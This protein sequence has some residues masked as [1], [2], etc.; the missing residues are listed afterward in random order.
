[1]ERFLRGLWVLRAW[2]ALRA[3]GSRIYEADI[4]RYAAAGVPPIAGGASER[5]GVAGMTNE[6]RI[7]YEKMLLSRAVPLMHHVGWGQKKSIPGNTGNSINFRRWERP[8][9][10]TTAIPEGS[11]P[12]ATALTVAAV[13]LTVQ[14]YG[15]WDRFSDVLDA[16]GIDD[17]ITGA[18][19]AFGE[20]MGLTIDTLAR[21]V[22]VAGTNVTFAGGAGSRGAI[23]QAAAYFMSATLLKRAQRE[24]LAASARPNPKLGGNFGAWMHPDTWD[25]LLNDTLIQNALQYA[26]LR[27]DTNP[28]FTGSTFDYAGMRL[29]RSA[30]ARVFGS[31]GLSSATN[32]FPPVYATVV[33][34]EEAYGEVDFSSES[35]SPAKVIV[36]QIGSAGAQDPLDQYGTVGWKSAYG[37]V[38]LN[39]AFLYRIES[40]ANAYSARQAG[41]ATL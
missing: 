35:A 15:A 21:D 24:L 31:A 41:N 37:A 25:D 30:N 2:R 4:R 39:E 23:S 29:M 19:G 32:G 26:G 12:A 5:I 28:L 34:A 7:F 1:M 10:A 40:A 17:F 9:V 22:L 14:Q 11:P 38:R 8:V 13:N 3:M 18:S 33:A 20:Q 16:Q 27:G 36:K 6:N